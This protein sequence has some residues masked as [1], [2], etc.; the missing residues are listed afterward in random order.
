MKKLSNRDWAIALIIGLLSFVIGFSVKAIIDSRKEPI[1]IENPINTALV[2][3][4]DSLEAVIVQRD[5]IIANNDKAQFVHDSIIIN[6]SKALKKDYD[7]IK[8][9]N[10]STRSAYIDSVL[11]KQ[12]IRAR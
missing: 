3:H 11:K 5:L 6:N 4:S 7:K 10:D 12:G 1:T 9:L 2:K 8:N